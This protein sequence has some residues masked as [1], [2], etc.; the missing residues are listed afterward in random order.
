MLVAW[1]RSMDLERGEK[2][3]EGKDLLREESTAAWQ[4][5]GQAASNGGWWQAWQA[6]L[7]FP[8]PPSLLPPYAIFCLLPSLLPSSFPTTAHLHM[9]LYRILSMNPLTLEDGSGTGFGWIGW[10]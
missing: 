6:C 7:P 2:E 1:L 9:D 8:L 3:E 5:V 4:A 10:T